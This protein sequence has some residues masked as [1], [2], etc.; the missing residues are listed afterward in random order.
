MLRTY[1][2][3][4]PFLTTPSKSMPVKSDPCNMK[5]IHCHVWNDVSFSGV[6]AKTFKRCPLPECTYQG[7]FADFVDSRLVRLSYDVSLGSADKIIAVLKQKY[8]EP[9]KSRENPNLKGTL[10]SA[11]WKNSVGSL[12][13]KD[14]WGRRIN[15]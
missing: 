6:A 2:S 4:T 11:T 12:T 14:F 5:P 8:G 7:K 3:T 15:L 9:T 1:G 13:V 10:S